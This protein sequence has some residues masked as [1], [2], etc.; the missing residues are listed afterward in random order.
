VESKKPPGAQRPAV[1]ECC[2]D[3]VLALSPTIRNE[4]KRY[5]ATGEHSASGWFRNDGSRHLKSQL[6]I[7][8]RTNREPSIDADFHEDV[9]RIGLVGDG[10]RKRVFFRVVKGT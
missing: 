5:Q 6:T 2:L 9:K 7:L 10:A 3:P 4:Q 1:W 8:Y